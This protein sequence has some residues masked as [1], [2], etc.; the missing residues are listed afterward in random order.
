M[1][2]H[3]CW[4]E[5]LILNL[6]G[7]PLSL[8]SLIPRSTKQ[9]ESKLKE[10]QQYPTKHSGL[11]TEPVKAIGFWSALHFRGIQV[12]LKAFFIWVLT[13]ICPLQRCSVSVLHCDA[14]VH[15]LYGLHPLHRCP[16]F[17][18]HCEVATYHPCDLRPLHRCSM[19][20]LYC[21]TAV[22]GGA[23]CPSSIMMLW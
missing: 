6:Y 7:K 22:R 23:V 1:N 2:E 14:V 15:H 21:E 18:L 8:E 4:D 20:L 10:Q 3:I 17:V 16:V 13:V 12:L 19:S 11:T 9:G 5:D